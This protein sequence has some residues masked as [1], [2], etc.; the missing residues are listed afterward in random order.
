MTDHTTTIPPTPSPAK[1][2]ILCACRCGTPITVRGFGSRRRRFAPGHAKTSARPI[3]PA[4]FSPADIERFWNYVQPTTAGGCWRWTGPRDEQ[5]NYGRIWIG[6]RKYLAHRLAWALVRG[7]LP[8]IVE[9]LH[10]CDVTVNG[11]GPTCVNPGHLFEG[12][13]AINAQD[14]AAKG[15]LNRV[16]TPIQVLELRRLHA[17]GRS[18]NSLAKDLGVNTST[19]QRVVTGVTWKHL[20]DGWT[21]APTR[22]ATCR[23]GHR[24][25]GTYTSPTGRRSRTCSTC[26]RENNKAALAARHRKNG[27]TPLQNNKFKT[28]C[29]R[30]HVFDRV[31]VRSDGGRHRVCLTCNRATALESYYRRRA[32][33]A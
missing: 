27:T 2:P 8:G 33:A 12:D 10:R 4:D 32:Q 3:D 18:A 13:H 28:L 21:P 15:T 9:L 7:P 29:K 5:N 31:I 6:T 20:A 24:F 22:P 23:K 19:V 25:D 26:R 14:G 16:L 17:T 30:G 11:L 1:A